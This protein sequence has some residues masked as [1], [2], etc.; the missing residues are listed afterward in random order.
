MSLYARFAFSLILILLRK[1]I[2]IQIKIVKIIFINYYD[3]R[4]L[5]FII[6]TNRVNKK[7][8]FY[9]FKFLDDLNRLK[10][11]GCVSAPTQE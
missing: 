11:K 5:F 10:G 8:S 4:C 1:V 6:F 9:F 2:R 3:I 7:K